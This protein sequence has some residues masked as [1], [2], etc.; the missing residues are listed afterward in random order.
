VAF[1][2][3]PLLG[4][5]QWDSGGIIHVVDLATDTDAP[6]APGDQLYRRPALSPAG[7]RV[8]AEGHPLVISTLPPFDT[9]VSR[10]G[11]IFLFTTP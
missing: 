7:D 8:A 4:P 2:V 1:S 10:A 5:V 6:L 11:D 9:T 3:D